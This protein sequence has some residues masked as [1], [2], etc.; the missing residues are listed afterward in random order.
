MCIV[1]IL[2]TCKGQFS[3]FL[4]SF[5]MKIKLGISSKIMYRLR[6]IIFTVKKDVS[7]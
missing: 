3:V 5:Y 7:N 2:L 1:L 6:N 4:V